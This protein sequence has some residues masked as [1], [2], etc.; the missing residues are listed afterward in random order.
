MKSFT[1]KEKYNRQYSCPHCREGG[2]LGTIETP[3]NLMQCKAYLN[4]REG[5]NPE[6]DLL[7]R[8]VYLRKVI[9]KRKE[10]ESKLR[11]ED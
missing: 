1:M 4:L 11:L 6:E 10:L 7:D 8:A 5:I 3:V 2:D 9:A